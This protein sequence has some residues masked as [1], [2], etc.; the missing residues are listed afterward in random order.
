VI[1]LVTGANKAP[2]VSSVLNGPVQP[3]NLPAQLIKPDAGKLTW[4]LDSQ[5]ASLLAKD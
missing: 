1:F 4:L 3:E 5:A 2:A